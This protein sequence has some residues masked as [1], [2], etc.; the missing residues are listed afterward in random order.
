MLGQTRGTAYHAIAALHTCQLV[1]CPVLS[2][3]FRW[4][5]SVYT[6]DDLLQGTF[7]SAWCVGTSVWSSYLRT[8]EVTWQSFVAPST[9]AE[10]R[11]FCG[12]CIRLQALLRRV[13]AMERRCLQ[14]EV[15]LLAA[16]SPSVDIKSHAAASH[17]TAACN[18]LMDRESS[19]LTFL[20][21]LVAYS[22]VA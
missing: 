5:S 14:R 7:S 3:I 20:N 18:G 21:R 11:P 4:L 22:R 10:C 8:C 17:E 16:R 1:V 13:Y 6:K 19:A 9:N 2:V 15:R 12:R